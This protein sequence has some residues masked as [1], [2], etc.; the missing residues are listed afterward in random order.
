MKHARAQASLP[1][2]GLHSSATNEH[3][4]PPEIVEPAR[5]L[6]G[7]FDLD[8]ASCALANTVVRA[9]RI[10]TVEEDGLAQP[11]GGRVFL[12]PPGGTDETGSVQRRWWYALA[13]AWL[14]GGVTEA[15]YIGFSVEILQRAQIKAPTGLPRPTEFPFVI[16][17]ARVQYLRE[18][19][20]RDPLLGTEER[21]LVA[22]KSPPHSSVLVYLP[23]RGG[24][25]VPRLRQHLGNLGALCG[26]LGGA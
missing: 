3:Y 17:S 15:F 7:G 22:G 25:W 6:L 18:D 20:V 13:A 23:P 16:P 14:R 12:N 1:L 26:P 24:A 21:R 9:A 11:W 2:A 10:H 19:V 8:P 5:A 4:T